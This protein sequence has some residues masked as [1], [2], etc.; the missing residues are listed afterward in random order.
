MDLSFEAPPPPPTMQR[1]A[2]DVPALPEGKRLAA[3]TPYALPPPAR[4]VKEGVVDS[5]FEAGPPPPTQ[6]PG[7]MEMQA[8]G[9]GGKAEG[10]AEGEA[11][12]GNCCTCAGGQ[13]GAEGVHWGA[14]D[15]QPRRMGW[16]PTPFCSSP[17]RWLIY[18]L[19]APFLIVLWLIGAALWLL[20]IPL[21]C[22]CPCLGVP[23]VSRGWGGTAASMRP[24]SSTGR[25]PAARM[26][27]PAKSTIRLAASARRRQL[28][29]PAHGRPP[30]QGW[31]T[32][33]MMKLLRLPFKI[34]RWIAGSPWEDD[35]D[36]DDKKKKGKEEKK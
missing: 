25:E 22:C 9:A 7:V 14:V 27:R 36:E 34:L 8:G 16:L 13:K 29:D 1:V 20:L 6:A 23:L 21:K 35:E 17:F 31:A 10:K 28:T 4:E 2:T 26:R 24:A 19:T 33:L 15:W 30:P 32:K 18:V 11:G 5:A 3:A 12:G